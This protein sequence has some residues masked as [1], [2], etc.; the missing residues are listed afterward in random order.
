MKADTGFQAIFPDNADSLASRF[1]TPSIY[2]RLSKLKTATGFT[3]DQAIRSGRENPDSDIGIYAGDPESYS[4]FQEI[5]D[6]VIRAFHRT[7]GPICHM[8]DRT[9]LDLDDPDPEGRY[10]LSTRI[11][12]A[13]N[14]SGHSFTPHM[15]P[16][17]RQGV[18]QRIKLV[19][20]AL[21]DPFK[22]DYHAMGDL[23]PEQ[24]AARAAAGTAFLPGD[25]FQAKAG[26]TC[27]FPASRGVY[28]SHDRRFFVWVNE[29]DH[30]R[31]ICLE[32]NGSLTR[33]FNRLILAIELL[34]RSLSFVWDPRR[35]YLN[36][37]PTN[38]GTAMRAGVHIRLPG[39]EK[40][41]DRLNALA[42]AYGLQIRGTRGEKTAVT[43]AV[44]DISN[45]F[46]LGITET[47][48]IENLHTGITAIIAAEKLLAVSGPGSPEP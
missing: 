25:R 32:D 26:I 18:E 22:G 21:P 38:I 9:P 23:S 17:A 12:T 5:F 28:A 46:R 41:P 36:A 2:T 45:R 4:L 1:L 33:V 24:I 6:P 31:I 8:S 39:L 35:G 7:S 20:A 14:L 10:I 43:G 19:V 47:R 34:G 27:G 11:R 40:H 16:D 15:T 48:L 42:S 37:C 13:R 30:L 44:F 29:E 3:L